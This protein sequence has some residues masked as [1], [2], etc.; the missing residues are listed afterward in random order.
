MEL[1][2]MYFQIMCLKTILIRKHL[3]KKLFRL[4]KMLI[5]KKTR[6]G[7]TQRPVPLT[8]EEEITNYTRK[9]SIQNVRES[10]VYMDSID[11]KGNKFKIHK[12]LT[13]YNYKN[14]YEKWSFNYDGVINI[15][16]IRL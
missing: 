3:E 4:L 12:I 5:K 10:K 14:S 7:L 15:G 16:L 2:H 13:G 1:L 9:D 11:A 6:S 8:E